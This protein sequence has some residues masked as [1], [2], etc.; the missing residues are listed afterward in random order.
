VGAGTQ[1]IFVTARVTARRL[2]LLRVCR[3]FLLQKLPLLQ[4]GPRRSFGPM[5]AR[6]RASLHRV[7]KLTQLRVALW[8]R[9]PHLLL[10]LRGP[11]PEDDAGLAG[12]RSVPQL[13]LAQRRA[14][15][16]VLELQSRMSQRTGTAS[17]S[18]SLTT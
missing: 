5:R 11:R 16:V 15:P 6:S 3:R 7:A 12:S 9:Y 8:N 13:L 2:L 4:L 1:L 18:V 14:K 17:S 10:P